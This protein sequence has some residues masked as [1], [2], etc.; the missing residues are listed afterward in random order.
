MRIVNKLFLFKFYAKY[1]VWC[2]DSLMF[3]S[4]HNKVLMMSSLNARKRAMQICSWCWMHKGTGRF[5]FELWI[6]RWDLSIFRFESVAN[7][8]ISSFCFFRLEIL[9]QPST[10]KVCVF[11]STITVNSVPHASFCL[12]LCGRQFILYRTQFS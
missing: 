12:T 5:S 4:W 8:N 11:I 3:P 7:V 1:A 2:I 10:I 6:V 9:T